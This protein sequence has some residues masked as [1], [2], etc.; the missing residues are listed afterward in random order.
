MEGN[1]W[2]GES[3]RFHLP[4][5]SV[6]LDLDIA[7]RHRHTAISVTQWIRPQESGHPEAADRQV[8][9]Q[10]NVRGGYRFRVGVQEIELKQ[11][12]IYRRVHIVARGLSPCTRREERYE[13]YS[14]AQ[15][16]PWQRPRLPAFTLS[17]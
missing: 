5:R 12:C 2:V 7:P 3:R 16:R 1:A 14:D 15:H 17:G 10:G 6:G 4:E 8:V 11:G 13:R 9:R